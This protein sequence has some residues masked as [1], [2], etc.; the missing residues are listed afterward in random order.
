MTRFIAIK[1]NS[2]PRRAGYFKIPVS[3]AFAVLVVFFIG[4]SVSMTG[5]SESS[6]M[7][8]ELGEHGEEGEGAGGEGGEGGGGE[9]GGSGEGGEGSGAEGGE[10]SGNELTKDQTYD[11]VRKG[12][13]LILRFD[14]AADAFVGTV[15]NTTD[16]TLVQVR[17]EVHLSN[18]TELGPTTPADLAPAMTIAVNLSAMGESFT[19]WTPHAEV[20]PSSGSGGE[21]GGSGEGGGEGG[22][23]SSEGSGGEHGGG[24][25]GG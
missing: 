18:G 9:H 5:C 17:V 4:V 16:S 20:G 7:G 2:I 8:P 11:A 24:G 6:P 12:A 1:Q 22:E 3:A 23:G 25:D 13:R 10:E 14:A 21:H 19:G 15:S